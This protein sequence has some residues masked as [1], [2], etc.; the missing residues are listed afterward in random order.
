[1]RSLGALLLLLFSGCATEPMRPLAAVNHAPSGPDTELR[2]A[3]PSRAPQG[4]APPDVPAAPAPC[5]PL[6]L[7]ELPRTAAPFDP[8]SVAIEDEHG[9]LR[10]FND[11]LIALVQGR[12]K[13][14]LRI[15]M[16]GDSNLAADWL[17]AGLRRTLQATLGDA[18]HGFVA[19]GKPW[20]GYSHMDVTLHAGVTGWEVF[21]VSTHPAPDRRLGFGGIAIESHQAGARAGFGTARKGAPVGSAAS[22]LSVLFLKGPGQGAIELRVDGKQ[23]LSVRAEATEYSAGIASL[24]LED[25]PHRVELVT[26]SGRPLRLFGALLERS[27]PGVV[28]DAVGVASSITGTMLRQE[29]HIYGEALALRRH[30]LVIFTHGTFDVAPWNPRDKHAAHVRDIIALHRKASPDVGVLVTSPV[31]YRGSL[32]DSRYSPAVAAS[33]N[34]DLARENRAAFWDLRAAMGGDRSIAT[35]RAHQMAFSDHIHLNEKGGLFMG[36]RLAHSLWSGL[37]RHL[38][39]HPACSEGPA[40][41]SSL[42][43][44]SQQQQ[45]LER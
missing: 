45:T 2:P 9:A 22:R 1:M 16:Y 31:D 25:S 28:V 23:T 24:A 35:F 7:P 37:A 29:P 43:S 39:L 12:R 42:G 14:P 32:G 11:K 18:G 21:A 5:Q 15:L 30:D 6:Q 17:S 34:R 38:E 3:A 41:P 20:P 36:N 44:H 26:T 27:V 19:L 10:A 13:E 33:E 8:P 40:S 4:A